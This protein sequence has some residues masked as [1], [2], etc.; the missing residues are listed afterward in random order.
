MKTLSDL[1]LIIAAVAS[2]AMSAFGFS[3]G[4]WGGFWSG[5]GVGAILNF[6]LWLLPTLSV[7]AFVISLVSRSVGL[8]CAWAIAIG[9]MITSIWS[10]ASGQFTT[11]VF[12]FPL[13]QLIACFTL[14]GDTLIQNKIRQR[15]GTNNDVG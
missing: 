8:K 1:L 5:T 11:V 6:L 15:L 14:Y 3:I 2:M 7:I 12:I 13:I 9:G 10:L 4:V